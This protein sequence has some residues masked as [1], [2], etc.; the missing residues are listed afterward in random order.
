MPRDLLLAFSGTVPTFG[1]GDPF[2]QSAETNGVELV[3]LDRALESRQWSPEQSAAPRG[4]IAAAVARELVRERSLAEAVAA[5][6]NAGVPSLVIKGAAVARTHYRAPHLRPRADAD[7]LIRRRDIDRAASALASVGF[8]HVVEVRGRE[9]TGQ[10][11]MSRSLPHSPADALDI[12]WRLS[13][14]RAFSESLDYDL[15]ADGAVPLRGLGPH[16]RGPSAGVA[17]A[18]ACIHRIAHHGDSP[19]LVWLWDVHLLAQSL[20]SDEAD[21]FVTL[22]ERTETRAVCA[23]SLASARACFNTRADLF[24]RLTKGLDPRAEP[25]SAF[26]GGGLSLADVLRS[27]LRRVNWRTRVAVLREH[28]LPPVDYM[29]ARYASWPAPMLPLAYVHRA[30]NGMPKWLRR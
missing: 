13:I 24:E 27:D 25:S 11:H 14:P 19:A 8:Q 9:T 10:F 26:I 7:L 5:L 20:S 22:A 17:L 4:L 2:W 18:I 16:G 21:R 15:L 1:A 6:A 30:L 28:V 12:H 3:L 23:A 29:R